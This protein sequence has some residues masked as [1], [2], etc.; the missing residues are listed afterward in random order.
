MRRYCRR[1]PSAWLTDRGQE[2]R[3]ALP[4]G[5][6]SDASKQSKFRR[7]LAAVGSVVA[8]SLHVADFVLGVPHST[9]GSQ[10]VKELGRLEAM[11][12]SG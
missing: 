12:R 5:V 8:V 6:T 2:A 10:T 9:E 1:S 3:V 7:W 4:Y 11:R